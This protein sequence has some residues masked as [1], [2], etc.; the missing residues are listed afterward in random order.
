LVLLDTPT[1][2]APKND[3]AVSTG[4]SQLLS[5]TNKNAGLSIHIRSA[6]YK[7]VFSYISTAA[8]RIK[9]HVLEI[10]GSGE[11]YIDGVPQS[12]GSTQYLDQYP[13]TS[14]KT[15]RGRYVYKIK[16]R[17]G[18]EGPGHHDE[19]IVIREFRNW[20]SISV[21]HATFQDFTGSTGLM[22]SFPNGEWVGRDGRTIHKT[23]SDYGNDWVVQTSTD[24]ESLFQIPS[25]FPEKCNLPSKKTIALRGRRL[26]EAKITKVQAEQACA[27]W[28]DEIADCIMDVLIADDLEFAQN[29]P[30]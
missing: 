25:P 9:N 23:I 1:F 15:K 13:V 5:T 30:L 18:P 21:Y 24:G 14:S 10:R 26:Q 19:E 4:S 20:I 28:G 29:G 22:G 3:V 2:G 11:Y 12:I 27:H 7:K 17:D 8:I 16:L 6:P